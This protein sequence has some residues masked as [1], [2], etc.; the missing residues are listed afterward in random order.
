MFAALKMHGFIVAHHL[1]QA[2]AIAIAFYDLEYDRNIDFPLD[3]ALVLHLSQTDVPPS[4]AW[5]ILP[6]R[7]A[8]SSRCR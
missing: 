6:T 1:E 4:H 3:C 2:R 8:A 5:I 7:M